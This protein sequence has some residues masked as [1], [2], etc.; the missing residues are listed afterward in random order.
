[1]DRR[2]KRTVK[3]TFKYLPKFGAIN[4]WF[5]CV[6][7]GGGTL[8][9]ETDLIP[10]SAREGESKKSFFFLHS[11]LLVLCFALATREEA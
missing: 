1:M 4:F 2:Q 8:Q 10:Y 3:W 6:R 7:G 11:S 5:A 9:G